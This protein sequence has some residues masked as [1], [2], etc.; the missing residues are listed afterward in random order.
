MGAGAVAIVGAGTIGTGWAMVFAKRGWRVQ[1]YDPAAARAQHAAVAVADALRAASDCAADVLAA[2]RCLRAETL[3]QALAGVDFVQ[4][5]APDDLVV[6]RELLA[7]IAE[8]APA[9]APIASSTSAFR[10][11]DLLQSAHERRRL[12]VGHPFHPVELIP[13]VEVVGSPDTRQDVLARSTQIYEGLGKVVIHL[14]RE[15]T[16]HLVNRL[17]AA[18]FREAT[19]LV[20]QGVATVQD[21]DR[22]IAY[23][24]ALRWPLTGVFTTWHL[25]G[26]PGG[27]RDYMENLAP[28]IE[29]LWRSLGDA[30]LSPEVRAL[31]EQQVIAGCG[32]RTPEEMGR[33]RDSLLSQ[34][35]DWLSA[36]ETL[37]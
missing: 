32:G 17:Q 33:L 30:R 21:I 3:E 5:S 36:R 14:K 7:A 20:A 27:V 12:L 34:L 6:K 10:P 16:G 29:L 8:R 19:H 18:L 23:G 13:L 28:S 9:N 35:T 11:S 22:G 31:I 15:C 2:G 24:P 25:A 4:E 37:V 26:G 1:L